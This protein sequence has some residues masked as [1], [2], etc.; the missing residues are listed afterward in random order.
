MSSDPA[1][2]VRDGSHRHVVTDRNRNYS[3][4][5]GYR[6]TWSRYSLIRCMETGMFWRSAGKYVDQLPDAKPDED[7]VTY[8]RASKRFNL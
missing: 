7:R 3:A 2:K 8:D 1:C 4:F 5:N 6:E